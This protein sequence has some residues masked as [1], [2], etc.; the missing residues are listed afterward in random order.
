VY[1]QRLV[2]CSL[3]V[4]VILAVQC[5]GLRIASGIYFLIGTRIRVMLTESLKKSTHIESIDCDQLGDSFLVEYL[6]LSCE[7]VKSGQCPFLKVW[8]IQS[9]HCELLIMILSKEGGDCG[10]N[11]I[12]TGFLERGGL[13]RSVLLRSC[14]VV[15][16][17]NQ[18]HSIIFDSSRVMFI[19]TS[20][21]F[22][23]K[24]R[25]CHARAPCSIHGCDISFAFALMTLDMDIT[26]KVVRGHRGRQNF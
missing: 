13:G 26:K 6:L 1:G 3:L 16:T 8:E 19:N 12:A 7:F 21:W 11:T 15:R 23:G 14:I 10:Q 9:L 22:S 4:S 5:R 20:Q 24:I 25:A 2:R 17:V 18:I